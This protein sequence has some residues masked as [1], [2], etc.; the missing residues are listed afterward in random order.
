MVYWAD[1]GPALVGWLTAFV[2]AVAPA[3]AV[4]V[5]LVAGAADAPGRAAC[6][7]ALLFDLP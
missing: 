6:G 5:A 4:A 1:C 2:V 3:L 7:R